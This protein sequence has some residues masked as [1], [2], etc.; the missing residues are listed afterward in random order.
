MV[1]A[2]SSRDEGAT[3]RNVLLQKITPSG[4]LVFGSSRGSLKDRQLTE[5]PR[6]ELVLRWGQKQARVRGVVRK[7]TAD[8]T[9]ASWSGM[10]PGVRLGLPLLRQGKETNE[11]EHEALMRAAI[12]ELRRDVPPECPHD[13]YAAFK[14]TP[15]SVEF[16]SG[17]HPSYINDR[18]LYVHDGADAR[19]SSWRRMRLQA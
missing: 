17:G 9:E 13:V 5:D 4:E 15:S 2:T 11:Q 6:A 18:F 19:T 16:Y 10:P 1:L 7:G 3:A 8:E 14:C 12:R